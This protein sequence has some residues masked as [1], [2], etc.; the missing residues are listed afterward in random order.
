MTINTELLVGTLHDVDANRREWRQ[1]QWQSCFAARA[2]VLD[3][4][5]WAFP[6]LDLWWLKARDDDPADHVRQ[7]NPR[8]R[9]KKVP[10]V[11]VRDRAAR[12]LGLDEEQ[13]LRLFS[14][15]NS[16]PRLY[17]IVSELCEQ[18]EQEA[19]A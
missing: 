14:A 10:C 13:A 12:V 8:P 19:A 5:E 1:S 3:G 9:T 15:T 2:A 4:G 11:H 17:T 18:A 6:G 16:L 7:V